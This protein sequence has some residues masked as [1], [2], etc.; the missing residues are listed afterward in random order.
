MKSKQ[1]IILGTVVLLV[2]M[3]FAGSARAATINV[4]GDCSTIPAAITAAS[5]GDTIIV[6]AGTYTE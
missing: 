6:A 3:A 1:N 2:L 5:D 4:P